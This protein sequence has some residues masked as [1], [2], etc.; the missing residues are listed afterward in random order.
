VFEDHDEDGLRLCRRALRAVGFR[1]GMVT[2]LVDEGGQLP[3]PTV[4]SSDWHH[5]SALPDVRSAWTQ[6]ALLDVVREQAGDPSARIQPTAGGYVLVG[7]AGVLGVVRPT[8]QE[9]L[10]AVL[11]PEGE[12]DEEE[13]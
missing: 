3:G 2:V 11:D 9:A 1:T 4:S 12:P 13:E 10:L 6:R 8:P 5:D 7:H